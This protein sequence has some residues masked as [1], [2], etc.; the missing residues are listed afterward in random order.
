MDFVDWR[1]KAQPQDEPAPPENTLKRRGR[2]FYDYVE[3]LIHEAQLRGDF[4]NLPGM[5]KPLNLEHN[6]A[7]G[8]KALAYD[9]LQKNDAAP[10]EIEL[11]KEIDQERARAEVKLERLI[12]QYKALR[13]R[14][15]LPYMREKRAYNQALEKASGE[16]EQTLHD[17][18]R[19]IL[20]LNISTPTALHRPSLDVAELLQRFRSAC[21]PFDV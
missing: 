4:S 3:E 7:A 21:P 18:N 1:K 17:I 9:L 8:D 11:M 5:G 19:K 10:P 15:A 13:S 16:Y 14:R 20:T 12:F 2:H 6:A